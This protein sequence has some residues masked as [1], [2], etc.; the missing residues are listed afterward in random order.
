MLVPAARPLCLHRQLTRGLSKIEGYL[1]TALKLE[2]RPSSACSA[3]QTLA[4]RAEVDAPFEDLPCR[5]LREL[6][7]ENDVARVL[8]GRDAFLRPR[9]ELFTIDLD[10]GSR[11]HDRGDLF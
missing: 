6:R 5:A 11:N 7:D 2:T 1:S 10:T 3:G 8:V 4:D 9:L